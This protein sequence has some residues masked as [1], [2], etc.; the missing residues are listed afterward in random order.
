MRFT[1][2]RSAEVNKQALVLNTI[3]ARMPAHMIFKTWKNKAF[4][5]SRAKIVKF[6]KANPLPQLRIYK[7]KNYP[8]GVPE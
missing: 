8:P 7:P 5:Q 1:E 6:S 2:A 3:E 4:F